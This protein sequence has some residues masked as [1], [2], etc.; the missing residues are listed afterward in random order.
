MIP[1]LVVP[2]VATSATTLPG[3][4]SAARAAATAGPVSR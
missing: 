3:S 1:A 2:A 4:G